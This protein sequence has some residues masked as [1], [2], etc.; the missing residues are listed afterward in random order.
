[1]RRVPGAA[2]PAARGAVRP[3]LLRRLHLR[4]GEAAGRLGPL[5]RGPLAEP[6]NLQPQ[7]AQIS[8]RLAASAFVDPERAEWLARAEAWDAR[9]AAERAAWTARAEAKAK[10]DDDGAA[11][12]LHA[13]EVG[14]TAEH[15]RSGR[16]DVPPVPA[17][18][19]RRRA[20]V[21]RSHSRADFR[22]HDHRVA[23]RALPPPPRV[24]RPRRRRRRGGVCRPAARRPAAGAALASSGG[25]KF[26]ARLR[27]G[28]GTGER[29]RRLTL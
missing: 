19:R 23:P 22:A 1:M 18:D 13:L 28:V 14:Y 17:A 27:G 26:R 3:L 10:A 7:I 8:A 6:P 20:T 29:A 25:V 9:A 16:V 21:R 12:T 2:L 5:C 24:P 11:A 4:V 15:A